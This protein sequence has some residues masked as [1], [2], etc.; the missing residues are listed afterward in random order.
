M[1]K[2][3]QQLIVDNNASFPNNNANYIT[4]AILRD[5]NRD[6]IDNTVNQDVYTADSYSVDNRIDNLEIASASFVTSAIT[7]SSLTNAAFSGNTL[8]FT[9]GNGTTFGVVIP[10]VSG[11]TLPA[12]TVSGSA[13]ISNLG[14]V[15]SS[16]TASSLTTASFS[17]NT[18]T[19]TK[20]NG[21]TFG[22]TIPDVSGS[23]F[24][25]GSFATTGSNTFTG[26]QNFNG[27]ITASNTLISGDLTVD[28]TTST[29][30]NG[31]TDIGAFLYINGG[32]TLNST[33]AIT[34]LGSSPIDSTF[35]QS[36][37]A[38]IN[39]ITGSGGGSGSVPA[40]TVSSSAQIV[41]Y[42]IFATTGSNTFTGN[43]LISGSL[44]VG[45]T[46]PAFKVNTTASFY[47]NSVF[48]IADG[49]TSSLA[50]VTASVSGSDSNLIFKSNALTTPTIVSG[51]SNIFQSPIAATA[52]FVRYIG[53]N[54]NLFLTSGSVPQVTSSV[55]IQP[56]MTGNIGIGTGFVS[57][58]TPVSSSTWTISSNVF[59]N[60]SN[61]VFGT[62]VATSAVSASAGLTFTNNIVN[63]GV[64]VTAYKTT[65]TAAPS[66]TLN[67]LGGT[68]T[69]N[70]D[71]SSIG[72]ANSTVQ[73][74]LTVNNS[75]SASGA[76]TG[77]ALTIAGGSAFFGA[78]NAL[79]A[80]GSNT[81]V[82]VNR[83]ITATTL[84]GT[85]HTA[86]VNLLGDN[87]DLLAVS[88]IGHGLS[89]T[90]SSAQATGAGPA[91]DRGTV[92]VGR[93]NAQALSNNTVF[94]V[95]TG[96]SFTGRRTGFLIDSGSNTFVEGTLNVSGSTTITGSLIL[97]SSNATEL[98]VIGNSEFTGSLSIQSGSA[99]FA[100][101][102]RQYNVGAFQ[103]NVTQSGS[104]NVSQS[105]NFEVTDISSGVSIASNSR[106]TLA[107]SGTYNIQFSAQTL[108]DAGADDVYIW[109]KK[110]GTN[111][112]ASAGHVVL[113][114]NEELIAAWNYVV[115][116]AASDYFELAWQNTAGD[117]V[118][119][120]EAASGNVPSIPSVILTVT[121]VR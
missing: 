87:S 52:T 116:A 16:V 14:F 109:L 26:V 37:D 58:R 13:Q 17:G 84:I 90:G 70:M 15:S 93:F 94:A 103:S 29:K 102:N 67:S 60:S 80:S 117:A 24:N 47:G 113:S 111:V 79:Y 7:A 83:N 48:M 72:M 51:S 36:V 11:S 22:V 63:G 27:A 69:L 85:H 112:Q 34:W 45:T 75:Y 119:L 5:F 61:V 44:E 62:A 95:G 39:A 1:G 21:T 71:S 35:S 101:G 3:K 97:S 106:I 9:K 99:F 53:G 107:N 12:G 46:S 30:L 43:Q 121:Q 54:S 92:L 114:N 19:F 10:D 105:M 6:M 49:F 108:A 20:G 41:N 96:T 86:S 32:L 18:L 89:I 65:L 55:G 82:F 23:T 59:A 57:A 120:S 66:I 104:A 33:A 25:T 110:N 81:T 38:R 42:G 2:T 40:G 74:V 88:L 31:N 28:P 115:D 77:N 73:G 64:N 68:L 8:T 76:G 98:F 50:F 56:V 91:A 4:P 100:N 78:Q 118:L